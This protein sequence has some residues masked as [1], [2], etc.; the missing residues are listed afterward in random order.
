MISQEFKF[1]VE[2]LQS[3][4]KIQTHRDKQH[5]TIEK[6]VKHNI[7][8]S[9]LVSEK[10]FTERTEEG[11]CTTTSSGVLVPDFRSESGCG[12]EPGLFDGCL[13]C[14]ATMFRTD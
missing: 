11:F 3:E 7:T 5:V 12:T 13:G 10:R 6:H 2:G 14:K 9:H 1:P 8:K 4:S